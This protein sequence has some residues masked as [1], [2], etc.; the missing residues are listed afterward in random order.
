[1]TGYQP[2]GV[3]RN[4]TGATNRPGANGSISEGTVGSGGRAC[5]TL[6]HGIAWL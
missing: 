4:R 1:M 5:Y 6:L 3:G 2:A